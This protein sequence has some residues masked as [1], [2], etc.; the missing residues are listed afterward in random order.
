MFNFKKLLPNKSNK[1]HKTPDN[2]IIYAIGDIH[3]RF[4]LLQQMHKLILQDIDAYKDYQKI[5]IY[6]GDYIDRGTNSK[7]VI[8]CLINNPL[9]DF[10][11]LYLKGNHE[12]AML[13][14]MTN[15]V[16]TEAW[17]FWGGDSTLISYGVD[18]YQENGEKNN[19]KK[20]SM[21]LQNKLPEQHKDFLRQLKLF[22]LEGDYMF[23]HA[24][25]RPGIDLMMQKEED[26]IMIR[27]EFIFA[28][29]NFE[30]TIVF[31]HTIFREPF[32]SNR[33]IG[34][35]T[36]AYASGRLTA[37]VFESDNVRFINT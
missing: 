29:D 33:R 21:D 15:P 26:L 1:P 14:F 25:V 20:L 13:G 5:V 10:K 4:D 2:T 35:D 19:I 36:G 3:G 32:V 17:M 22:H 8:E 27:N 24:G 16:E 31:G 30:K 23:V 12:N 9:I 28:P 37:G 18:L 34:L 7:E 6:L 11:K